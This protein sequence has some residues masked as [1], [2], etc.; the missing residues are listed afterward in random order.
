M[1][2]VWA[3]LAILAASFEPLVAKLG[4]SHGVP[5][6]SLFVGRCIVAAL[7]VWPLTRFRQKVDTK[8]PPAGPE[9]RG[10]FLGGLLLATTSGLTLFALTRIPTA[11]VV[12]A[13]T[14]T[15]ALVAA[16]NHIRGTEKTG[17]VFWLGVAA[18]ITGVIMTLQ[19]PG[20]AEI[21]A[22]GVTAI[23]SAVVSSCIYRVHLDALMKRVAPA[24]V[25]AWVVTVQGI[26]AVVV[27]GP[28]LR[29]FPPAAVAASLWTGLFAALAN[30]AFLK[31]LQALGSTKVSVF[32]LAQRPF[33]IGVA[34]LLLDEPL[35][36]MQWG[37]T[38]LVI[39]GILA[40]RGLFS[41]PWQRAKPV[42]PCA[43][44]YS[45]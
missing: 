4:Y 40:T 14:T 12:V 44:S 26:C 41:R 15:P 20:D 21:D 3:L 24:V 33:I 32:T 23:V 34:A 1:S 43:I 22:I 42:Q 16:V 35:G 29:S 45:R 37:G 25:S 36:W 2:N 11:I 27:F 8:L 38:A 30:V 7:A 10:V 9:R 39:L 18:A 28:L 6:E 13:V 5:L 17:L 19:M 31:A